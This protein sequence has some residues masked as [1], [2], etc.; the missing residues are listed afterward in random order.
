MLSSCMPMHSLSLIPVISAIHLP[1]SA[2]LVY[3]S[4]DSLPE[5]SVSSSYSQASCLATSQL[6]S[7]FLVTFFLSFLLL[8]FFAGG[9]SVLLGIPGN[10]LSPWAGLSGEDNWL[11]PLVLGALPVRGGAPHPRPHSPWA[12]APVGQ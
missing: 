3:F 10:S 6:W 5:L 9:S 8:S 2:N 1:D 7:S 4:S 11:P 12:Q